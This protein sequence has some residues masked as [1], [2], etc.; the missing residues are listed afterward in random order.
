MS[1]GA[2]SVS[3]RRRRGRR[4][5]FSD[6]H[7]GGKPHGFRYDEIYRLTCS[8]LVLL[9]PW[10]LTVF[11]G[12]LELTAPFTGFRW[13]AAW[14]DHQLPERG[15]WVQA[16]ALAPFPR[17][18]LLLLP[19]LSATR[20]QRGEPCAARSVSQGR[21]PRNP[22]GATVLSNVLTLHL[23]M[24]AVAVVAPAVLHHLG[25]LLLQGATAP[26]PRFW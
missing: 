4:A 17:G 26:S 1:Q 3:A 25:G 19:R 10:R 2:G 11:H 21:R 18:A 5:L 24:V 22:L 6:A 23:A 14:L 7:T 13:V 16:R 9:R 20:Y 15:L 12:A 8:L